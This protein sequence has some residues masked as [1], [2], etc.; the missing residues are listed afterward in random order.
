MKIILIFLLSISLLSSCT[1]VKESDKTQQIQ[2]MDTL[3]VFQPFVLFGEIGNKAIIKNLRDSLFNASITNDN[4]KRDFEYERSVKISSMIDYS[5]RLR[6]QICTFLPKMQVE[7]S[8]ALIYCV[9]DLE[10][11]IHDSTYKS[12]NISIP[13]KNILSHYK[14]NLFLITDIVQYCRTGKKHHSGKG[15]NLFVKTNSFIKYR[16]F[17]IDK[18]KEKIVYYNYIDYPTKY[19][20]NSIPTNFWSKALKPYFKPHI[21][22]RKY[23][24]WI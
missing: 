14:N 3:A 7:D 12:L 24:R 13:M 22:K 2:E 16:V 10:Q 1:T 11:K 15:A 5:I 23:K 6:K 9:R 19:S 17:V 8:L 4:Y 18:L 21:K 20:T